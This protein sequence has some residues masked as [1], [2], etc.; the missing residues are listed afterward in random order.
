MINSRT[1]PSANKLIFKLREFICFVQVVTFLFL[2]TW[3]TKVSPYIVLII[4]LIIFVLITLLSNWSITRKISRDSIS[5]EI[6]FSLFC[7]DIILLSINLG[8]TGGA[9]NPFSVFFLIYVVLSSLLLRPMYVWAVTG[10]SITAFGILLAEPFSSVGGHGSGHV[11]GQ[12]SDEFSTHLIGMWIAYTITSVFCAFFVTNLSSQLKKVFEDREILKQSQLRLKSVVR[13]AAG[14]AHE[15][16]TPL[17]TI[18]LVLDNISGNDENLK[19]VKTQA[20]RCSEIIKKLNPSQIDILDENLD[21]VLI[22]D[23]FK[24][25]FDQQKVSG[26]KCEI[27]FNST[28]KDSKFF[29]PKNSLHLILKNLIS[30]AIYANNE[31]RNVD[32]KEN[33]NRVIVSFSFLSNVLEFS[34][35]DFGTGFTDLVLSRVGE[36][37]LTTKA[38]GEGLGLGLF[39]V[40][41]TAK[42]YGGQLIVESPVLDD[43]KKYGALVRVLIPYPVEVA[44]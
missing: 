28:L 41:L 34:V 1:I 42:R 13:L 22:K 31:A 19:I 29:L 24:E 44:Y 12:G 5:E 33:E 14:A 26:R 25:V 21:E 6:V 18:C 17:N 11:H 40:E 7:L 27:V 15:L 39:I 23:F 30:N 3:E 35:R 9:S 36:P 8:L 4:V 2:S 16:S 37:F 32:K 43:T 20:L 38:Q 10:L